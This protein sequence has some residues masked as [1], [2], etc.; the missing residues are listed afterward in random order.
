[1]ST[2]Q[3]VLAFGRN[4]MKSVRRDSIM[5]GVGL[6]PFIYALAMWFLPPLTNLLQRQYAFDL[7]PYHVLIVSGFVIVGPIAVLGALCGLMLLDEKDQHTLA[8]LRIAPIPPLTYPLYRALV[9][10]VVSA[11]SIVAALA[12]TLQV[13]ADLVLKSIPIGLVCGT[14]AAVVGLLMP[15]VAGN[16]VEGLAVMRAVGMLLFGLP[17]IPWWLDSP[18]QLLFG[19]LPTYWPAKAYWLAAEGATYWP[20]ILGGIAYNSLLAY[21]LLRRLARSAQQ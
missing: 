14:G 18:W 15:A 7:T 5:I 11:V 6:G 8:A 10:T 2:T 1:M 12:L 20:Y 9:T 16:K 21:V 3:A 19:L 17:L 4:D 13:P